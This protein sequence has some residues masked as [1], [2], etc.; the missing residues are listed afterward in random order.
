MATCANCNTFI[1]FGGKR[2]NN[3]VYCN[4]RC[5][6]AGRLAEA[7][8]LVDPAVVRQQV[9]SIFR[10]PCPKCSKQNGPVDI[11]KSHEVFS[12]LVFTRWS[13]KMILSCKSCGSKKQV[14]AIFFS[15]LAG[16]WGFPWGL[17]MTPVQLVRNAN[18]LLSKNVNAPSADLERVI[19][20]QLGAQ[21]TAAPAQQH[22]LAP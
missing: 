4:D 1:V 14:G 17:I 12:A 5:L 3:A 19:R 16:W 6:Q 8:N 20:L 9:E 15:G 10:G 2:L 7:S 18:E 11:R 22:A 21:R 13:T